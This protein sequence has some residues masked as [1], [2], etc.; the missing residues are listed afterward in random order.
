[1]IREYLNAVNE[2]KLPGNAEILKEA[3]KIIEQL[4]LMESKDLEEHLKSVRTFFHYSNF[5]I[6]H[7][8]KTKMS[9]V[10][11]SFL[12]WSNCADLYSM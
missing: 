11:F 5:I 9:T 6:L 2:Q 10:L 3:K 12:I 4:P 8:R 1:M 7:H